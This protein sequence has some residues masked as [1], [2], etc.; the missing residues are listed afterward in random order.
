MTFYPCAITRRIRPPCDRFPRQI[1]EPDNIEIFSTT[2]A[3]LNDTCINGC[4]ALLYSAFLS[5][6]AQRCAILSTHDLLRAQY[7]AADDVL[8][9]N[10]SWTEYWE[11]DVW[12]LPIHQ[13]SRIGHWVVC[14]IDFS[15][16]RLFLFDSLADRS[17]WKKDIKV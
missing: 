8:W 2:D 5:A 11:K 10:T 9:R 14:T 15:S 1:F 12:I 4:G 3:R 6:D 16:K 17:S 13:P 7:N